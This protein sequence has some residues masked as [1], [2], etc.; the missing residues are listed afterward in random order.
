MFYSKISGTGSF[1]PEAILTNQDLERMVDTSDDWITR[2]T[3]IKE[4]RIAHQGQLSSDMA[5]KAAGEALKMAGLEAPDLD[6]IVVGT[7]TPDRQFPSCAC[8]LQSLNKRSP[9]RA[10]R[11]TS[12][13]IQCKLR[14]TDTEV[15]ASNAS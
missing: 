8:A 11:P 4:R 12:R 5:T 2:R 15:I 14:L 9:R 7:V 13:R 3:G 10:P 6:L 1:I